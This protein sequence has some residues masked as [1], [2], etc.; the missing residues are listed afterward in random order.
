MKCFCL[1]MSLLLISQQATA[2]DN[3]VVVLD[4]SGSMDDTMQTT[5]GRSVTRMEA[6]KQ[7]LTTTLL[8]LPKDTNVGIVVFPYQNWVYNLGPIEPTQLRIAIDSIVPNG[9][10]PLGAYMKTGA[11]AL[12]EARK[13]NPYGMCRLL[14]V[15]DGEARDKYTVEENMDLILVRGIVVNT[16]GVGMAKDHQLAVKSHSYANAANPQALLESVKSA[17]SAEI[18]ADDP[19]AQEMFD[20]IS[21]LPD[22]TV[23]TVLASL[24]KVQNQPLGEA[25][26]VQQVDAEGKPVVDAEGNPVMV[27]PQEESSGSWVWFVFAGVAAIFIMIMAAGR[28]I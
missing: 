5:D 8:N 21:L 1:L 4:A 19:N 16:I 27:P 26:L 7:V 28:S 12:L 22:E 20:T 25:P 3:V 2:A 23:T 14:I 15:T 11:D 6:A 17:L 13:K 24:T 18:T 9:G 10:T